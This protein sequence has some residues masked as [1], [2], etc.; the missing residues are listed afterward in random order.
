MSGMQA[1]LK[2]LLLPFAMEGR[3]YKKIF[4]YP[5]ENLVCMK[6][7]KIL[8]LASSFPRW[9]DDSGAYFL[10]ELFSE[11]AKTNEVMVLVPLSKGSK[12]YEIMNGIRVFR[13]DYARGKKT[14]TDEGILPTLRKR[15]YL[16]YQLPIFLIKQFLAARKLIRREQIDI[17]HAHWII[18]QGFIAYLLK[19]CYGMPYM[20]T[21]W[22]ADMFVFTRRG[23]LNSTLKWLYK[24]ILRNAVVNT[25]VNTA[26]LQ[27]MKTLSDNCAY[28]PNC[29]NADKFKALGKK[30]DGLLFV[31][32]LADK[33]GL[34]YLI[35]AMKEVAAKTPHIVLKVVG[36]GPLERDLQKLVKRLHPSRNIV[37]EGAQSNKELV[38]YYN[39][40]ALFVAP[41]IQT[42]S[43]D[44]DG[45][46]TVFLEAMAC[47]CPILATNIDGINSIIRE[48][49]NGFL[50]EQKDSGQLAHA[51]LS[52]LSNAKVRREVSQQARKDVEKRYAREVVS[53]KY[54][55]WYGA[56]T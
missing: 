47:E 51:I 17:V 11:L 22:G 30:R 32:R 6:G 27:E 29:V 18:P 5:S 26:F 19:K 9:K 36:S 41:F 40:S 28:I 45:F 3:A 54:Q 20:V 4:I 37:F 16:I 35:H 50:V 42:K 49:D 48:G 34:V 52:I 33:K 10:Y 2:V 56:P 38:R 1:Y 25:T 43:G 14:M 15:P 21:S 55:K 46:P 13:F 7:K 8:M 24:R 31:G 12:P 23:L 39:Q 53:K 44:R